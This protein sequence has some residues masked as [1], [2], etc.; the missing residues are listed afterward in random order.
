[1]FT[2]GLS[3]FQKSLGSAS[4]FQRITF[5]RLQRYIGFDLS[6]SAINSNL[7][8]TKI[9]IEHGPLSNHYISSTSVKP[10]HRDY[11]GL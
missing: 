2:L 10:D 1:M 7:K 9:N 5:C 3:F 4:L 8:G 11:N 6:C